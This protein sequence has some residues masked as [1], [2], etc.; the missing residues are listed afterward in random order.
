MFSQKKNCVKE[1]IPVI[2]LSVFTGKKKF[3]QK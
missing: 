2:D 3:A 1:G